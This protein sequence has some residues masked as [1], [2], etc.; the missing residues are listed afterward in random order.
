[1]QRWTDVVAL[2]AESSECTPAKL[3]DV[4]ELQMAA[5]YAAGDRDRGG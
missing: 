3:K 4:Q 1:M 5:A 2:F